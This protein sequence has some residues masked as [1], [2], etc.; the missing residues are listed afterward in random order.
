MGQL[1]EALAIE[2]EALELARL[3]K[4]PRFEGACLYYLSLIAHA[5]GDFQE[6]V[7]R[8]EESA[9]VCARVPPSRAEALAALAQARLA[10]GDAPSA[11]EAAAEAMRILNE[12]GGIDEG[13]PFI[14]LMDAETLHATGDDA[15]SRRAIQDALAHLE[16]R[17]EKLG[18]AARTTFFA[19]PEHARTLALAQSYVGGQK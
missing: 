2:T 1:D 17:A 5:R 11:R 3:Q 14:R 12:V 18:G 6:A 13:E 19:V 16:R 8:A 15:A 4:N 7:R 10:M 9:E